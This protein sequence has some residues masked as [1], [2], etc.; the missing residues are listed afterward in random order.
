MTL[1][2]PTENRRE[3]AK[4]RV[5]HVQ[6]TPQ[7][8]GAQRVMLDIFEQLD[9]NRFELHVAC[10]ANGPLTDVLSAVGIKSHVIPSL[11]RSIRPLR[12]YRAY[13]ELRAL[14]ERERFDV[15][16]THSSKPGILGRLAA[17]HAGVEGI[18]HHVQGFAFHEFTPAP[19]RLLGT[20]AERWAGANCD[21]IV[22]VNQEERAWAIQTAR[23]P[24]HKCVTI[25]NGADLQRFS[26]APS[27]ERRAELRKALGIDADEVAVL[28]V[29][30]LAPQ[31]QPLIIPQVAKR[32]DELLPDTAWRI[33]VAGSGPL[34]DALNDGIH[35]LGME[36]RVQLLSWQDATE[37]WMQSA[38]VLLQPTLWEGL[39]LAAIEAMGAGIPVVA[40]DVKGN[41]E[42]VSETT[43]SLC[44]PRSPEAFARALAR[45]VAS[46]RL[47][48]ECGA[49]GR[50][51]AERDFDRVV[52]YARFADL[53]EELTATR[54]PAS[55]VAA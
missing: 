29:G 28:F 5:C 40:A 13:A 49:E 52:N 26:P 20:L 54:L 8:A 22:F 12:D 42:A 15:V 43:G 3:A 45:F 50:L 35:K 25:Y 41:R 23:L 51:R 4:I 44:E 2:V 38:D 7:L 14:F 48:Q 1:K 11:V 32:L 34:E 46:S 37:Q 16:H 36:Q 6:T 18:V 27:L 47:R 33:L 24:A 39:P 21:R 55:R 30:R 17:R 53:Y 31:K 9:R 19:L 10:G